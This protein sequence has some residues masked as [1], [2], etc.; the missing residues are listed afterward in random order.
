ME[1]LI[2]FDITEK[3]RGR[4]KDNYTI[5]R[6]KLV[7]LGYRCVEHSEFPLNLDNI[8]KYHILVFPCPDNSKF[9]LTEIEALINYVKNGGNLILLSHAGGDRGRRTNLSILSENFGVIFRNDQVFDKNYNLGL[10]SFPLINTYSEYYSDI[11]IPSICYRI[12]CSLDVISNLVLPLAITNSTSIPENSIVATLSKLENGKVI[13]VGSYEMFRDEVKGGISYEPNMQFFIFLIKLLLDKLPNMNILNNKIESKNSKNPL[14]N[15]KKNNMNSF[16]KIPKKVDNSNIELNINNLN[17]D[18]NQ[19]K[20]FK[21]Q[22]FKLLSEQQKQIQL[23]NENIDLLKLDLTEFKDEQIKLNDNYQEIMQNLM[24]LQINISEHLPQKE[25]DDF[26][27]NTLHIEIESMRDKILELM[28][29]IEKINLNLIK[30]EDEYYR[31]KHSLDNIIKQNK[32]GDTNLIKISQNIENFP[33]ITFIKASDLCS[34]NNNSINKGLI[35]K[36][37]SEPHNLEHKDNIID[38]N[39][40]N[41]KLCNQ[42]IRQFKKFLNFLTKQYENRILTEH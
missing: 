33:D 41:N 5:I 18:D 40:S 9:K 12:G 27:I 21:A 30:I 42:K 3:E 6:E 19:I 31:L 20:E 10:E 13:C 28:H 11:K 2:G 38:D 7:E 29:Q 39:Y 24:E 26:S 35:E 23:I 36:N 8:S 1:Y 15:L 37:N 14:L 34:I 25:S 32:L 22:V 17:I 16:N 4:I